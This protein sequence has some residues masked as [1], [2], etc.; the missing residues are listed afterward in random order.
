MRPWLPIVIFAVVYFVLGAIV[1]ALAGSAHT[2]ELLKAWRWAA[3]VVIGITFLVEVWYE[4]VRAGHTAV[5]AAWHT[6]AALALYALLVAATGPVRAHW[7]T[8]T[9]GRA[10]LALILWPLLAGGASFLAAWIAA[11]VLRPRAAA[12]G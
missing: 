9:Q 1:G 11:A 5:A 2:L 4:R 7:G 12:H 8:P 10:V 3:W 6:A